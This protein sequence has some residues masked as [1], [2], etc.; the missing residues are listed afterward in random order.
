[1]HRRARAIN[2]DPVHALHRPYPSDLYSD[3]EHDPFEARRPQEDLALQEAL[4]TIDPKK[5][6]ERLLYAAYGD[7]EPMRLQGLHHLTKYYNTTD[8]DDGG[9]SILDHALRADDE[10]VDEEE[11]EEEEEKEEDEEESR[12]SDGDTDLGDDGAADC[13]EVL[14][15][16]QRLLREQLRPAEDV[17]L[18]LSFVKSR[19][20]SPAVNH[21]HLQYLGKRRFHELADPLCSEEE[22]VSRLIRPGREVMLERIQKLIDSLDHFFPRDKPRT[23]IQRLCHYWYV[24]AIF[25]WVFGKQWDIVEPRVLSRYK[26]KRVR[27]M[28][29]VLMERRR[30]KTWSIASF[31]A[32][33]LL[34][35]PGINISI[36]S[37][38]SMQ[39]NLMKD[40]IYRMLHNYTQNTGYP[41]TSH[42]VRYNTK[43]IM[44]ADRPLPAG[45]SMNSREADGMVLEP[46]TSTLMLCN[47][48]IDGKSLQFRVL[49][50][51]VVVVVMFVCVGWECGVW[52]KTIEFLGTRNHP[53]RWWCC[54][55][56]LCRNR[57]WSAS[58]CRPRVLRPMC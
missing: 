4:R 7:N 9:S 16:A 29:Q 39:S 36:F 47:S 8:D 6:A 33:V 24:Q 32:A 43:N 34:F 45:K 18:G 21:V 2:D 13:L 53:F 19:F 20:V 51:C 5:A 15:P 49:V 42:L 58:T 50:L 52:R 55:K 14:P 30:G 11:D 26:L 48:N 27:S 1:M 44:V 22:K 23:T 38:T 10:K 54:K 41:A 3:G 40:E 35:I 28:V 56:C 25:K 37:P 31:L 17:S 57:I 46:T 12:N